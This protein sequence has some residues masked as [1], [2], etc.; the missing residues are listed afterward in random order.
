MASKRFSD[1][2]WYI[3]FKDCDPAV[4]AKARAEGLD[5]FQAL[6]N[7]V[8]CELGQ[9]GVDFP[10]VTKWLESRPDLQWGIVEQDILPGM[11]KPKESARR[12]RAYLR[13]IG[14]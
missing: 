11:G 6:G 13:S 10:W 1:R 12:N 14:L 5:Y 9:G 2:I 3:H 7:G 8:F 4:A